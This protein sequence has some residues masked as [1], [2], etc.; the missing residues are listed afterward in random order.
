MD[1]QTLQTQRHLLIAGTGR[2]G[3]SFLVRYLDRLGLDT[4]LG[5]NGDQAAWHE[6]ANAGLEDSPILSWNADLPYVI[7]TP[8]LH[9]VID[10]V[11][12]DA[13]IAPD[14]VIIPVR[15]LA[16]AA[17]SRSVTEWHAMHRSVPWMTELD[18]SWEQ[19]GQVPG[20]AIY[21]LNPIDQGRLLAVGFHHLVQRLI[22]ADIPIIF[23]AF[24]RLAEDS[25]YLFDRLRPVLPDNIDRQAARDAHRRIADLAKV[26]VGSELDAARQPEAAVSPIMRHGSP[27]ALDSIA[28]RRELSRLRRQLADSSAA[29]AQAEA[30]TRKTQQDAGTLRE[31]LSSAEERL[32]EARERGEQAVIDKAAAERTLGDEARLHRQQAQ[33]LTTEVARLRQAAARQ[34]DRAQEATQRARELE[35]TLSKMRNSRSW[36]LTR[37][38]RALGGIMPRPRRH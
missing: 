24:P 38:Y 12:A 3:T 7:K 19:W 16:E 37:A 9:Q 15:D 21:S 20:G 6:D 27:E 25:D 5:R 28:I 26:R 23:L 35:D 32:A 13:T 22:A 30:E 10:H 31:Q 11:L 17:A 2:A 8:W 14:A 4:H 29:L 33:E 36:R 1:D 34:T 18:Q